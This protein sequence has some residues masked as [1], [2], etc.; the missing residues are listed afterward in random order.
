M[1]SAQRTAY[2]VLGLLLVVG[3]GTDASAQTIEQRVARADG[4]VEFLF[5][6]RPEVCG[7]GHGMIGNVFE[8]DER[9]GTYDG[10][11]RQFCAHGPGRIVATVARGQVT[12]VRTYVGPVNDSLPMM[13]AD[14]TRAWL[15][16][17]ASTAQTS[18]AKEAIMPL[19]V[20][21]AA[22]PWRELVAI[23]RDDNRPEGVRR[24]ATFWLG[25]AASAR[26]DSTRDRD[27]DEDEVKR[28][29]VFALSQ[30]P[31][32]S[33]IPL[34][35]NIATGNGSPPVRAAAMFWLG[36]TGDPRSL[37]V[38]ARVLDVSP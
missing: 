28:S 38:F 19:I 12:K 32:E 7:D 5:P 24:E 15:I 3:C 22:R 17:L 33:S 1:K 16:R 36:Q 8:R 30:Q 27:S 2:G 10:N 11:S 35:I 34:L 25:Q 20:L 14:E 37:T 31:R 26:I 23:G 13:S 18:V 9:F 29:A 21:D 4:R 6:S